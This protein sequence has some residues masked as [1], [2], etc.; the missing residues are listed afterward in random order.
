MPQYVKNG[1]IAISNIYRFNADVTPMTIE[2]VCVWGG[3]G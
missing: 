3:G 2:I 1:N